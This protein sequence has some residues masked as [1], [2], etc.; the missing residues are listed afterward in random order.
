MARARNLTGGSASNKKWGVQ[1]AGLKDA[2]LSFKALEQA[3]GLNT[4]KA[5]VQGIRQQLTMELGNLADYL[6]DK[7]RGYIA[8][9]GAPKRLSGAAFSYKDIS[10][11]PQGWRGVKTRRYRGVLVGVRKGAPPRRDDRLYVEWSGSG[12]SIGMSLST[13][14]EK[15][16][17]S[18]SIKPKRF[19]RS[20]VFSSR[21]YILSTLTNSYRRAFERF[22]A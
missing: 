5:D 14:F 17:R 1:I 8:S 13:L 4:T 22:K 2:Q 19:F 6:R 7:I 15:G 12:K 11:E 10:K 18:K 16:T 20:A 3:I 21:A 9:T